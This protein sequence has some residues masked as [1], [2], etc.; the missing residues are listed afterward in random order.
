MCFLCNV[1]CVQYGGMLISYIKCV[2]PPSQDG[3]CCWY[4]ILHPN[5]P[6]WS[7]ETDLSWNWW[8]GIICKLDLDNGPAVGAVA[9]CTVAG[10]SSLWPALRHSSA[11]LSTC[12]LSCSNGL[13]L[14]ALSCKT[15]TVLW[16]LPTHT[17]LTHCLT[18]C[19]VLY[20]CCTAAGGSCHS[21]TLLFTVLH[22]CPTL[23]CTVLFHSYCLLALIT[24]RVRVQG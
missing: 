5:L 24:F 1:M 12:Q 17:T 15:H 20:L 3:I 6:P 23:L 13:L 18:Q 4:T 10:G 21:L 7:I 22:H 9:V 2:M 16:H 11:L 8:W 14:H 19:D